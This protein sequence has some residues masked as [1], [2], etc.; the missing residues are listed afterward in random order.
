M[1]VKI[2]GAHESQTVLTLITQAVFVLLCFIEIP[3]INVNSVNPKQ[4][5]HSAASE[6]KKKNMCVLGYMEF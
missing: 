4:M 5:P 6:A 1:C 3:V 2:L